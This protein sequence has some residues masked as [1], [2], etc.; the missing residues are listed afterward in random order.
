MRADRHGNPITAATKAAVEQYDAALDSLL[1]FQGSLPDELKAALQADPDFAMGQALN[2]YL[3]V[4]GT[5]PG[6]AA[7]AQENMQAYLGR[8][9]Q[10]K[11]LE[12]ERMHLQAA[13]TLLEGDFQRAG[14]LLLEISLAYPRD[15]LAIAIGHQ[16]DFFTGN[17]VMLRDRPGAA[18]TAWT[19]EDQ[20]YSALLGM[21]SFGLEETG[22]YDLSEEVGLEAVERNPKNVWAIHAV[23]H[24]YEMQ[25]RFAKGMDYLD[26]RLDDWASGN[27]F[28]VHNWWHYALYALEAGQEDRALHIHD[29]TIFTADQAG[30]AL[31]LL[32]ASALC[33]RL[34]LNGRI[35]KERFRAH[36]KRWK[37]KVEP[38]FYAFN[39]MHMVMA[40]VGAGLEQDAEE[41][42]ASR[43]EWL[44]LPH[45]SHISNVRMTR[46][47]G[48]PVCKAILAFGRGEY[49]RVVELLYPIRRRLHEFGGSHAQRDAVLQ[50]LIEA[51]LRANHPLTPA[52]LSERISVKPRSPYN[53]LKQAQLLEQLGQTAKAAL[54]RDTAMQYRNKPLI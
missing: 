34:L 39:D 15:M 25:G 44:T 13:Q 28:T 52:L 8:V 26:R 18:R 36:A 14:E 3:G 6:D 40:F 54:A 37:S 24:T 41:L 16:I 42:I 45:P 30:F 51:A 17:A 4:L 47:I 7:V 27:F 2:G 12:R 29:S 49:G 48:L 50:T 43:Q 10:S 23:T 35:E 11:L 33:W 38:A 9:D 5:E 20:H 46:D 1:F 22:Q 32:D 53:W 21:L 31:Q 19:P